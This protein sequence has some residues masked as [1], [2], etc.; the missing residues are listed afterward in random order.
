MNYEDLLGPVDYLVIEFPAEEADFSGEI[1]AELKD[2]VERGVVRLLDL[3]LLS[4][5]RRAASGHRLN[6]PPLTEG[7]HQRA[8]RRAS[9][10]GG[11]EA[12]RM[13]IGTKEGK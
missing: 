6:G 8:L 9:S 2:L 13:I 1:A 3:V 4:R 11:C 5:L 12:T 7:Q 10:A